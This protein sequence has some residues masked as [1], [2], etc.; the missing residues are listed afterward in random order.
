MVDLKSIQPSD[1]L[2]S[3]T[4]QY[5]QGRIDRIFWE[6]YRLN[7]NLF[8]LEKLESFPTHLFLDPRKETFFSLVRIALFYD[9]ILIETKLLTDNRYYTILR[10]HDWVRTNI[11]KEYAGVLDRALSEACI[12]SAIKLAEK[13]LK[14]ARNLTIAHLGIHSNGNIEIPDEPFRVTI[15]DLRL[16]CKRINGFFDI[17]CF[18]ASYQKIPP[19]Y[20][21][22]LPRPQADK[23]SDIEHILDLIVQDSD[24]FN[25]PE[26][27]PR[28]NILRDSYPQGWVKT[29]NEYRRKLGKPEV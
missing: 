6:L 27:S 4:A 2:K 29:L 13:N 19:D 9:S 7:G 18:G 11:R 26:T 21:P 10:F 20:D 25:M 22:T 12:K 28:W 16:I 15:Q 8:V 24:F 14:P 3:G 23:T 1:A 17:L 5:Y